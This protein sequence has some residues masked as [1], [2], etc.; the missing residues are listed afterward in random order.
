M[1]LRQLSR[2]WCTRQPLNRA[3][4]LGF[5]WLQKEYRAEIWGHRDQRDKAGAQH[6]GQH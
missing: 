2:E 6:G 1:A 4:S 5:Q 3:Q